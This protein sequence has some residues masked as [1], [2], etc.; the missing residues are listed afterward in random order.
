MPPRRFG[1]ASWWPSPPRPFTGWGADATNPRAVASVFEAKGRPQFNPL[2]VHVAD[3]ASAMELGDGDFPAPALALAEAF[4]P[5][6]LTLVV[7]RRE[8]CPVA[9]LACAGL[10]TLAIRVP[11]HPLAHALLE[12]AGRPVV[13]PS[14]NISGQ[15]SPTTAAHVEAE[16]GDAVAAILDGGPC[17]IGLESTIIGFDGETPLLLRAGGVTRDAVEH[18]LGEKLRS[19][20]TDPNAPSAPGQLASHYAPRAQVRLNASEV[21]P[22]EALLGFGPDV[23]A[24]TGMARNLSTTGDLTEAAANLFAFLRALDASGAR[25]I[26]V[27]PIPNDGLGEAINDRLR[28]AAAPRG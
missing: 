2:I 23:P 26:A 15:V 11:A 4:W 14:A 27:S 18:R 12:Q 28:R 17:A 16:L 13:A 21:R 20:K 3:R 6:P 22:G 24:A 10:N 5:G 19:P 9:L 8:D 1:T 25:T 7:P